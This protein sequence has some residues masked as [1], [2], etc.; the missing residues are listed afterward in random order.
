M[1]KTWRRKQGPPH[2]QATAHP[3][4]LAHPP[5]SDII[6]LSAGQPYSHTSPQPHNEPTTLP[7]AE[8]A[9]AY[10]QHTAKPNHSPAPI[11]YIP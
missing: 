7:K 6:A 5:A 4:N 1:T 3:N 10:G 2:S 8:A 11:Y 9:T